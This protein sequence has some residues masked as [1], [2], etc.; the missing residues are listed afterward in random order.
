MMKQSNC[1]AVGV[2]LM[3]AAALA[4]AFEFEAAVPLKIGEMQTNPRPAQI[5]VSLDGREIRISA[6]LSNDTKVLKRYGYYAYTPLFHRLGEGEEHYDKSFPDFKVTVDGK[7]IVLAPE[8][9]AYFLGKDVTADVKAV[10]LEPLPSEDSDAR[11]VARIRLPLGVRSSDGRDWEGFASYSWLVPIKPATSADMEIRYR[12]LPQFSLENIDSLR[13]R[14]LVQQH[15]GDAER[16]TPKLRAM[17]SGADQLLVQRYS[18]PI[19]FIDRSAVRVSIAQPDPD[20]MG[21]RPLVAL[22]CGLTQG[23]GTSFPITGVVDDS[24]AELS[25]LVIS[26]PAR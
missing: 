12:A 16:V 15:C 4:H 8:R 3:A 5:G 22:M 19:A 6:L 14:R 9:R 24:D 11:T 20:W 7:P 1:L 17:S 18:V 25:I 10:G 23:D 2:A 21:A 26:S 13:L